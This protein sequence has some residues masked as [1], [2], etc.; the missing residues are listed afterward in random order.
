LAISNWNIDSTKARMTKLVDAAE[1][2]TRT[3]V[4]R[5]VHAHRAERI[6]LGLERLLVA[7]NVDQ[8]SAASVKLDVL[9]KDIQSRPDFE[10]EK[11]AEHLREFKAALP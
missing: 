8:K 4:S 5:E 11:F 3:D 2:F 6:V 10:P 7:L 9:F 1:A